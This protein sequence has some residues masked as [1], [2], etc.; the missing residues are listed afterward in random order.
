MFITGEKKISGITPYYFV[1]FRVL[2]KGNKSSIMATEEM[3]TSPKTNQTHK[4]YVCTEKVDSCQK[5]A[6]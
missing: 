2:R 1:G 5:M 6:K 4:I 3:A